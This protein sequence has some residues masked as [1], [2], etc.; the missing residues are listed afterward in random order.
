MNIV[1][2]V[3]ASSHVGSGHFYR[4]IQI[5]YSLNNKDKV[6]FICEDLNKKL[7]NILKKNRIKLFIL[8]K[9]RKC[10]FEKSDYESTKNIIKKIKGKINLMVV[11]SYFLGVK[12]EKK[13]RSSVDKIL[14][15]D[16]LNR[17]HDCDFYLNQNLSSSRTLDGKLRK[18]TLKFLGLKYCIIKFKA[19]EKKRIVK[20]PHQIKKIL[21]FMGGSDKSN[22]TYKILKI[23]N[24]KIFLKFKLK[25]VVGVDNKNYKLIKEFSK[26][27][28]DTKIYYNQKSLKNHILDSDIA[29]SSGGTFIWECLFYG[30]PALV[31]NQSKN[32]VDNSKALYKKKAIKLYINE[33]N[34]LKKITKFLEKHL[35]KNNFVVPA[36]IFNLLDSK[37]ISRIIKRIRG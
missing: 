32:Q 25:I 28:K 27:R 5:A 6:F 23:L 11:D 31:L 20:K 16:D 24:K 34:D 37:G 8:K 36:K 33:I 10:D 3:N 7:K 1:F 30:L 21:I 15:I 35:M 13:I 12:W 4:C 17:K 2:R 26:K 18:N 29:I 22:L 14:V 19:E 9:K